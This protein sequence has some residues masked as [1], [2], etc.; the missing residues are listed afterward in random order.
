MAMLYLCNENSFQVWTCSIPVVGS[1]RTSMITLCL[2]ALLIYVEELREKKRERETGL[3]MISLFDKLLFLTYVNP[4]TV[5]I[6]DITRIRTL[7]LFI[8]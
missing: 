3:V 6:V 8:C 2:L 1:F 5:E 7:K 4:E